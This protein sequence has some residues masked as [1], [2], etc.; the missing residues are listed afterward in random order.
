MRPLVVLHI[1]RC[2]AVGNKFLHRQWILWQS[3]N[4]SLEVGKIL[5]SSM[6]SLASSMPV[7]LSHQSLDHHPKHIGI[8][9]DKQDVHTWRISVASTAPSGTQTPPAVQ[10]CSNAHACAHLCRWRR[11]SAGR[12]SA[13]SDPTSITN[14]IPCEL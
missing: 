5:A 2:L 13:W 8:D 9:T 7:G 14:R 11:P 10:M 6:D 12:G 3:A 4:G 1:S